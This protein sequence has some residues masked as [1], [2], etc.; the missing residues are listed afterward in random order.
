MHIY[1]YRLP[2]FF[3]GRPRIKSGSKPNFFWGP[4]QLTHL[5]QLIVPGKVEWNYIQWERARMRKN[6]WF[7]GILSKYTFKGASRLNT[8]FCLKSWPNIYRFDK[9][10]VFISF[11][12]SPRAKPDL[13]LTLQS[14]KI[15]IITLQGP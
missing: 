9:I 10:N 6:W 14:T 2:N 12:F 3:W 11:Y 1:R 4:M 13:I 15:H 5:I 8:G 7:W